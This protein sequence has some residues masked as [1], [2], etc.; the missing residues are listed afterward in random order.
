M[1]THPE[2][3]TPRSRLD[4]RLFDVCALLS[5]AA[6]TFVEEV[7]TLADEEY[8][9]WIDTNAYSG[10]WQVFP[11]FVAH[12]AANQ[13]Y[14]MESNRRRCP[15]TA[16]LLE[17]L[18]RVHIASF[19]RLL[20]GTRLPPHTDFPKEGILRIHVGLR[21][22]EHAKFELDG[23][24]VKLKPGELLIFDHSLPHTSYNDGTAP[25][26]LLLVDYEVSDEERRTLV[27]LRG[28]VNLGPTAT[29]RPDPHY[30]EPE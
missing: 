29:A 2:L 14:D 11:F 30:K 13:V 24:V 3:A 7:H 26:D 25:R 16:A 23:E 6:S 21:G 27:S 1:M 17:P 4:P 28:G 15:R 10:N 22:G 19:S 12:A 18:P 5:D 9:A 20:P 8:E